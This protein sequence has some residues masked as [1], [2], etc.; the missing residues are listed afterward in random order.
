MIVR[1]SARNCDCRHCGDRI[2][3]GDFKFRWKSINVHFDCK[4]NF[5]RIRNAFRKVRA[6]NAKQ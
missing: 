5:V 6:L 3:T 2:L 1:N 4:D